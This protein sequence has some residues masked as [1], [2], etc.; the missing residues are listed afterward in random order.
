MHFRNLSLVRPGLYVVATPI[1][2]LTDFSLRAQ[3][4]LR[5]VDHILAEDT[6]RARQLLEQFDINNILSSYHDHNEIDRAEI[7]I[8]RMIQQSIALAL[9][10]DSGTPL[11]SDPG[12]RLVCRGVE[13]GI[14]VI[15][16]P[17]PSALIACVSVSNVPVDKFVFE[18]F[19]S[20][21]ESLRLKRLTELEK[22]CRSIVFYEA[23]HRI[24]KFL[25][26]LENIMGPN[27]KVVVGREMTKI[28]EKIY[29]GTLKEVLSIIEGRSNH[30]KGEF[31]IVL[32]GNS[33]HLNY[34][35]TEIDRW[36]RL[37]LEEVDLKT[38]ARIVS[39][40]TGSR[41]N[42]IYSRALELEKKK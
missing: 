21:K 34:L 29:R 19:L 16:V 41:K 8:N 7:V 15:P 6:R 38:A 27:R 24:V 1:G 25:R 39:E 31:T 30:R 26:A 4:V 13:A 35:E 3:S 14:P 9:I 36:L 18:G 28:H 20:S 42:L 33:K 10:S 12:Y 11:I 40:I 23:P 32:E 22:E 2:N 37:L 5:G 17:G